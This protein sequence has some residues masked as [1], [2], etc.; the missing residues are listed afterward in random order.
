MLQQARIIRW[1]LVVCWLGMAVI[2]SGCN[3]DGDSAPA[4]SSTPVLS[5]APASDSE[6]PQG[7]VQNRSYWFPDGQVFHPSLAGKAVTLTFEDFSRTVSAPFVLVSSEGFMASGLAT[8]VNFYTL[9]V[10]KS[11]F[12]PAP[13]PPISGTAQG[14]QIGDRLLLHFFGDT[15]AVSLGV[16]QADPATQ[17]AIGPST[18]NGG[19]VCDHVTSTNVSPQSVSALSSRRCLTITG[20]LESPSSATAD[21]FLIPVQRAQQEDLLIQ[22]TL[23]HPPG[24]S[25][26]SPGLSV[27]PADFDVNVFSQDDPSFPFLR[28]CSGDSSPEICSLVLLSTDRISTLRT[29]ISSIVGGGDYLLEVRSNPITISRASCSNPIMEIEPNNLNQ[30]QMVGTVMAGRCLQIKG[31]LLPSSDVAS[32]NTDTFN[33]ATIGNTLLTFILTPDN[34]TTDYDLRI[35]D[36][37][38]RDPN[39][40]NRPQLLLRC[41][42]PIIPAVGKTSE[43]CIFTGLDPQTRKNLLVS[44]FASSTERSDG[45]TLEIIS[46][47]L[48]PD[49]VVPPAQ[50]I[51]PIRGSE[52]ITD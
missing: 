38:N 15:P 11:T 30:P 45:Y 19:P 21:R 1:G 41:N 12:H 26:L 18:N 8:R 17:Q 40:E 34:P 7:G 49:N 32:E 14:P 44:V 39:D 37:S 6:N 9:N 50:D 35:R 43:S 20:D 23:T 22:F 29:R 3:G 47:Q 33:F 2:L 25:Q 27:Q 16:R 4:R 31:N 48:P 10:Q 36:P 46:T 13:P 52:K 51:P 28:S 5:I 42:A 24:A